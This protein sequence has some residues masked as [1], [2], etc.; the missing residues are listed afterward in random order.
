M[1]KIKALD[2]HAPL[3]NIVTHKFKNKNEKGTQLPN[4]DKKG[5]QIQKLNARHLGTS[6]GGKTAAERL[7]AF[8]D[9]NNPSI[10]VR[11]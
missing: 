2:P 3:P 4:L 7:K 8:H 9:R 6:Y 1:G 5:N 10:Q 11:L